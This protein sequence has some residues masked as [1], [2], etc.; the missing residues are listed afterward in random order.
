MPVRQ[1]EE[2]SWVT[3]MTL[4]VGNDASPRRRLTPNVLSIDPV[5]SPARPRAIGTRVAHRGISHWTTEVSDC[6]APALQQSRT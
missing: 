2:T 3:S 1:A 5:L 6:G 4:C